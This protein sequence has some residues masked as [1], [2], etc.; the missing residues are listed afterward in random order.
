MTAEPRHLHMVVS[1]QGLE[2]TLRSF[3]R[4]HPSLGL[5]VDY[6]PQLH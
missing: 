6:L 1:D 3:A 5:T 4:A 2:N